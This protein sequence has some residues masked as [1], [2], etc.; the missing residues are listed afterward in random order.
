MA[1]G[2]SG[3]LIMAQLLEPCHFRSRSCPH[4]VVRCH[5]DW[6]VCWAMDGSHWFRFAANDLPVPCCTLEGVLFSEKKLQSRGRS[7]Q[8]V[9]DPI[10]TLVPLLRVLCMFTTEP[11]QS[12]LVRSKLGLQ[13]WGSYQ[14]MQGFR[15]RA[16]CGLIP[17]A[18]KQKASP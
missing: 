15:P 6:L 13:T 11:D 5:F 18:F 14:S 7:Y 4:C 3:S 8:T 2:L 16:H 17:S 10:V 9:Y 12:F 1:T